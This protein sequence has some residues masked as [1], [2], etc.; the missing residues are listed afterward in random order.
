VRSRPPTSAPNAAASLAAFFAL[1]FALSIPFWIVGAATAAELLPGLP[2]GALQGIVPLV[3]AVLLV[4]RAS[5]VEG[6]TRLMKRCA[7]FTRIRRKRWY[8][9]LLL[10]APAM[11][12]A[13][14]CVMRAIG[15]P[16]PTPRFA[17]TAIPAMVV[18]FL[19]FALAEELGWSAYATDAMH[20]RWGVPRTGMLLGLVWAAWH[21]VP[22]M[23]AH[24]TTP[25]IA[26]WCLGTV[27][28]RVI[29]VWL[30]TATRRSVF[31]AA[32]YHTTL[33]LSWQLFPN[34]GSHYDP[35]V[36]GVVTAV[37]AAAVMV[38]WTLRTRAAGT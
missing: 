3:A 16:L 2:V 19:G 28:N 13:T 12:V 23:Q 21:I 18:A 5:G 29:I 36:S 38:A 8:V 35:R 33:N 10:L 17:L 20:A 14:Y 9:P 1:V 11:T 22:L 7:D 31:A 32:L 4:R 27:A 25:W 30:Y 37:I 6:V 34:R 24:R 26:G 15:L